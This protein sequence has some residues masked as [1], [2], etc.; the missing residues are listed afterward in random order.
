MAL[1]GCLR[2]GAAF[3][4]PHVSS[5]KGSQPTSGN[6]IPG[7]QAPMSICSHNEQ[8]NMTEM[9]GERL[10]WKTPGSSRT[11][12]PSLACAFHLYIPIK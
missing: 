10:C 8:Q 3:S 4:P 5:E 2:W 6:T 12:L 11:P 1:P 7:K 9:E